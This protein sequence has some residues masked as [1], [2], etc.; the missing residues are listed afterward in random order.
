MSVIQVLILAQ[1]ASLYY[2]V[3]RGNCTDAFTQQ[4]LLH[5]LEHVVTSF[6][7]AAAALFIMV[8][9]TV[10]SIILS[11]LTLRHSFVVKRFI[12]PQKEAKG[13]RGE[14]Q[15]ELAPIGSH[16]KPYLYHRQTN[17]TEIFASTLPPPCVPCCLPC[18]A[19]TSTRAHCSIFVWASGEAN[20]TDEARAAAAAAAAAVAI[21]D[22]AQTTAAG[23]E[24]GLLSAVSTYDSI[25]WRDLLFL[26]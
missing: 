3:A 23:E 1:G 14:E 22:A 16:P 6:Y 19:A 25:L 4:V 10:E 11:H 12:D 13:G 5:Q 17:L 21:D 2:A 18:R 7:T 15:Y 24:T 20:M 8:V 9:L 26:W